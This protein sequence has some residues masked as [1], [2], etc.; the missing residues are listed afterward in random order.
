MITT[1]I[2]IKRWLMHNLSVKIL[3]IKI[4][5]FSERI[6]PFWVTFENNS[7]AEDVI[8]IAL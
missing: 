3:G 5:N 2:S 1:T 4:R 7:E 8:M 6:G